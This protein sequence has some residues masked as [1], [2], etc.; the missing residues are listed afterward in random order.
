MT[1]RMHRQSDT[2]LAVL[3]SSPPRRLGRI[4]GWRS[5]PIHQRLYFA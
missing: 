5:A 2:R 1:H 4:P 3:L